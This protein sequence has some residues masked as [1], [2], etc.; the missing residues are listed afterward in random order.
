[1][2]LLLQEGVCNSPPFPRT[3]AVCLSPDL[4]TTKNKYFSEMWTFEYSDYRDV[5]PP[6]VMIEQ[7]SKRHKRIKMCNHTWD[8]NELKMIM[9][10]V[11]NM[12]DNG[13]S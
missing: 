7:F 12:T 5:L 3:E 13:W 1:M 4:P 10:P 11:K 9:K 6:K 2:N 8:L